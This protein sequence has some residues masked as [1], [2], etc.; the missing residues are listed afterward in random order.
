MG[1]DRSRVMRAAFAMT[2]AGALVASVA[3]P[4][5]AQQPS[6]S[7]RETARSLMA[8][9]RDKRDAGDLHQASPRSD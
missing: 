4:A 3:S 1:S 9:G 6:A 7:D 5:F 8:E 2:L